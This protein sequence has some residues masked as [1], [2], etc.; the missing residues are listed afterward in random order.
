MKK[1]FSVL[2]AI[3]LCFVFT[4]A[5]LAVATPPASD[6]ATVQ[7][8]G[9]S[10]KANQTTQLP[11][12]L[13]K[14]GY[15]TGE[16]GAYIVMMDGPIEDIMKANIT[17][18]GATLVEYLPEFA[19]LATMTPEVA[20]KVS[21]LPFVVDVQIY[22]PAYKISPALT[23][24]QGNITGT[25]EVLVNIATWENNTT[26]LDKELHNTGAVKVKSGN[27]KVV[28]KV[29][30]GQLVRLAQLNAVKSIEPTAVYHVLNDVAD[31]YV[32]ADDMWNLGYDG[33]GQIVGICDTGLDTGVNDSTMH[34]DF[35]GRIIS[36]YPLGRTTADDPHGHGTHVTGSVLGNGARSNGQIKG[37]A[38][39]AQVVF[40]SVLDSNGGLG[41]LPAD[42]NTVFAQAWNDGARIHTNSWGADVNT[43]STDSQAVDTFVWNNKEMI[44]LFAA[45]ND[46]AR[47]SGRAK[48]D[49]VGTPATAKNCITVGASENDRPDKGSYGDDPN[50]IAVFS[51][52][53]ETDDGRIKPDVV[54]PG[55]WIL[56]TRSTLAPDASFWGNYD[57]YY[58]YM[59]GTSMATPITA[60]CVATAREFMQAEW[61][62]TPT[63][64]LMK[65]ALINGATD[66]GYGVPSRDQGWGRVSLTDS[67]VSKE[68][69]FD[70]ESTSL[71]TGG[72][73]N[74]SYAV[75]SAATPLRIT[76]VWSDYPAS[77]SASTALVN[78]LDLVVTSP[79]GVVYC[80]NDFTSP[81]ND[82]VDRLNNVENVFI[83]TPEVGTYTIQ[84]TG[85]N[86]PVGPQSFALFTSADFN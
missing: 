75:A 49:S 67:L 4:A 21:N 1:T 7:L 65:A 42:L 77:T 61:G 69:K 26:V 85:Y 20:Q 57:S 33:S 40:Q 34:L 52:R 86:V 73:K 51:S 53:G 6:H 15:A 82:S 68:Y 35:Q 22:Q 31:S 14:S 36:I 78:D 11:Y 29:N 83:G 41:G 37:M 80:G 12:G 38:P 84:V 13:S 50:S 10:V 76:V 8:Q 25:D 70:N 28:V 48:Y 71:S 5:T 18:Q 72:S 23:D 79:S 45:G 2:L 81:F 56:S 74:Y 59:G 19:F 63:G 58:A 44:I 47:P 30:R 17:R 66:L 54:A 16:T 3:C 46:G 43:Y 64:A 62:I 39:G 24:A 9:Y 55:T 60:G 27:K 32:D